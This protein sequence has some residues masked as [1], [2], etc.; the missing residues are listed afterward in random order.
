ME[1]GLYLVGTPIG[2]L[3]DITLR[4]L[5]I[6]AN[7]D[8]IFCEDTRVSQKLLQHYGISKP[9]YPCFEHN[10]RSQAYNICERIRNGQSIALISDAGTPLISDP[11][12]PI[13]QESL[14]QQIL[15]RVVPGPSAPIC[16]LLL[17]GQET[18]SFYFGGFFDIQQFQSLNQLR[19]SLIF[20][21]SPKRLLRTL[22]TLSTV[23]PLSVVRE[24]TKFYES[25]V[26]GTVREVE[27]YFQS[28]PQELRGEIVLVFGK[29]PQTAHSEGWEEA[30]LVLKKE[31]P[32]KEAARIV[33]ILYGI[34]K[35]TAYQKGLK[36]DLEKPC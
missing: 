4:A 23:R 19:A 9:L 11:G 31:Y 5:E 1:A 32:L 7:V 14:A 17:S 30:L 36:N 8:G 15:I 22:Q 26:R 18:D 33:Q 25:V 24:I 12:Y 13:L 35:R 29:N 3:G 10:E 28:Q 34:S 21:E 20:F 6:L 27:Q 16:A 2:N